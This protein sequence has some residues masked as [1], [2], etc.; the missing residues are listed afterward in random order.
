MKFVGKYASKLAPIAALIPGYGTAIAGALYTAGKIAK[1]MQQFDVKTDKAGH[2]KFKSPKHAHAFAQALRSHAEAAKKTGLVQQEMQRAQAM[3]GPR[4]PQAQR[5][6]RPQSPRAAL[7][8]FMP[9]VS[10][11]PASYAPR[12]L[13]PGTKAH[14]SFLRGL[15]FEVAGL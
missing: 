12:L 14:S 15:G 1:V 9:P 10:T 11:A 8:A 2:P 13:T 4:A 5:R 6:A 7:R 3:R